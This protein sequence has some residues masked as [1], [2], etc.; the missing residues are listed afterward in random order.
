MTA[1]S[2]VPTPPLIDAPPMKA[3]AMASSSKLMP[4]FGEAAL[5]R[6]A[7]TSPA[8]AASIPMFRKTAKVTLRSLT[9]DSLAAG[10]LP[11]MA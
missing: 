6:A 11:P 10:R 1:P 9:P 3:A 5:K 2:T 4:A 7:N 8:R